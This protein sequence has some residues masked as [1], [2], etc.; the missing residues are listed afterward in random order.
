MRYGDIMR[1]LCVSSLQL[2]EEMR[3]DP[4]VTRYIYLLDRTMR[5]EKVSDPNTWAQEQRVAYDRDD[6]REF[7][8]LRGYTEDEMH[9]FQ[10]YLD[11]TYVLIEKYSE[12]EVC[13][14]GYTLQ[15]ET[16]ILGLAPQQI[17][18]DRKHLTVK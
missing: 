8:R 4:E 13:W 9:D 15:E 14:I 10:T 1:P 11:L 6:W 12:D 16:G 2:S 18:E 5:A 7:S 3:L 17:L